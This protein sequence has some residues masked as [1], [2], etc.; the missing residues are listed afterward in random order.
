MEFCGVREQFGMSDQP[1]RKLPTVDPT[2]WFDGDLPGLDD[3]TGEQTI[4]AS[5]STWSKWC[6]LL[7]SKAATKA[8]AT[9]LIITTR[10][11]G[12]SNVLADCQLPYP[13]MKQLLMRLDLERFTTKLNPDGGYI[14][15]PHVIAHEG[16]HAEGLMHLAFDATPDLM[17]QTYRK[18]IWEPQAD[19]GSIVKSLYGSPRPMPPPATPPAGSHP[20]VLPVRLE[21]DAYGGTYSARGTAKRNT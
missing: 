16:G 15:L 20:L 9:L 2:W 5:L 8:S 6:A 21:F 10:I 4:Q 12:P 13:G 11:D 3:A 14:G 19:E 1:Q 17:N 18:D 7:W